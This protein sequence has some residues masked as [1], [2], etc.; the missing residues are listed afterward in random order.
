MLR[1]CVVCVAC[2]YVHQLGTTMPSAGTFKPSLA[3]AVDYGFKA[4]ANSADPVH[5]RVRAA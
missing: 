4:T 1:A 2:V 5:P 3:G